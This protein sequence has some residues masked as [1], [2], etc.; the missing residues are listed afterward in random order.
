MT[1]LKKTLPLVLFAGFALGLVGC[2]ETPSSEEAS[3][4]SEGVLPSSNEIPSSET[5]SATRLPSPIAAETILSRS[6]EAIQKSNGLDFTMGVVHYDS[7]LNMNDYEKRTGSARYYAKEGVYEAEQ[8]AQIEARALDSQGVE[9][10]ASR[11]IQEI[12]AL[13]QFHETSG[14][15][16][17][18]RITTEKDY[19]Y[20]SS[21]SQEKPVSTSDIFYSEWEEDPLH[22]LPVLQ[23]SIVTISKRFYALLIKG[24]A[25]A[26]AMGQSSLA[27]GGSDCEN[28]YFGSEGNSQG[29]SLYL[30]SF[31]LT[32]S[33]KVQSHYEFQAVLDAQGNFAK[34]A[35]IHGMENIGHKAYWLERDYIPVATSGSFAGTLEEKPASTVDFH[36]SS[37]PSSFLDTTTLKADASGNLDKKT[38][39]ALLNQANHFSASAKTVTYDA[40]NN[41]ADTLQTTTHKVTTVKSAYDLEV[42]GYVEGNFEIDNETGP[43]FFDGGKTTKKETFAGQDTI[44]SSTHVLSTSLTG[45]DEALS[46][47]VDDKE[48]YEAVN[49][50]SYFFSLLN[51]ESAQDFEGYQPFASARSIWFAEQ[52]STGSA[53]IE[54]ATIDAN[55]LITVTAYAD[56]YDKTNAHRYVLTFKD[57]HLLSYAFAYEDFWEIDGVTQNFTVNETASYAY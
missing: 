16:K 10:G 3:A 29:E 20:S 28:V 11:L 37:L 57:N 9:T 32:D 21:G 18:Y 38:A 56:R 4:S 54:S 44:D 26:A 12:F 19:S 15:L 35:E 17:N 41:P 47:V 14:I 31:D 23:D 39:Y 51:T 52:S 2:G 8:S 49:Y 1:S 33:S 25:Y 22:N 6:A 45:E 27:N 40:K 7:D 46:L 50:D 48:T 42:S 13:D 30:I 53:E 5:S 55:S 36:D 24:D 34:F 43:H